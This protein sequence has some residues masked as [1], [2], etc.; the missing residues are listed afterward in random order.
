MLSL[1]TLSDTFDNHRDII[2]GNSVSI[3]SLHAMKMDEFGAKGMR[4]KIKEE[5]LVTDTN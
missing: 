1:K 2:N 4:I 5:C 3:Y